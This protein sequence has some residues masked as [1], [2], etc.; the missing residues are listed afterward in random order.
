MIGMAHSIYHPIKIFIYLYFRSK[1]KNI[2]RLHM[3][4]RHFYFVSMVILVFSLVMSG[5]FRYERKYTKDMVIYT[6]A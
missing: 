6:P 2:W 4:K 3:A 1:N 5:C